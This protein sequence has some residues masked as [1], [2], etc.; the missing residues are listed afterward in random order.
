VL[1][2]RHKNG[3]DTL[4][5]ALGN[6]SLSG[7]RGNDL[8]NGDLGGDSYA[9]SSE[10]GQDTIVDN[11]GND[12]LT[13]S[14]D[15]WFTELWFRRVAN[16]LEISVMTTTDKITVQNWYGAGDNHMERFVASDP[17]RDDP[18]YMEIVGGPYTRTLL[19]SDVDRLVNAMAGMAP[20]AGESNY[21][22]TNLTYLNV[23]R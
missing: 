17:T 10:G 22:A 23:W 9:F 21:N 1:S 5:G 6:D 4:I 13:F 14:T 16:D 20:P 19:Y 12:A 15:I 2:A 11:G 7:D 3:N 8:L 18:Y